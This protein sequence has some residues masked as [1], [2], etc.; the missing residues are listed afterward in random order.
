MFLSGTPVFSSPFQIP[1]PP[2]PKHTR[3]AYTHA[4]QV[5][6]ATSISFV[7]QLYILFCQ[8]NSVTAEIV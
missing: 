7:E 3:S 1:M 2:N 5:L 4:E 6:R 8:T